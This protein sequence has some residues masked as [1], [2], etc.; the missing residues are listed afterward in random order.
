M[1]N[2]D[3][4]SGLNEEQRKQ[5]ALLERKQKESAELLERNLPNFK[6][7]YAMLVRDHKIRHDIGLSFLP[8]TPKW[9]QEMV[10][11]IVRPVLRL[12]ECADEV[13][14]AQEKDIADRVGRAV[15]P[16]D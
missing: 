1:K 6:R 12:K 15:E 4:N 2:F 9:V 5:I 8:D 3:K 11:G 10:V 7:D 13:L 14:K 16:N